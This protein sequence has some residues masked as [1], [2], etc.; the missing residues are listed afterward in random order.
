MQVLLGVVIGVVGTLIAAA[1][2]E[3]VRRSRQPLYI[4]NNE[5]HWPEWMSRAVPERRQCTWILPGMIERYMADGYEQLRWGLLRH[6]VRTREVD[7]RD[8][9][10]FVMVVK[11]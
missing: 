8:A 6:E 10:Y 1:I 9:E 7:R 4:A 11:R 3:L 2:L 5:E